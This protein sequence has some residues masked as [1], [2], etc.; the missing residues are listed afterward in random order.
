MYYKVIVMRTY[1]EVVYHFLCLLVTLRGWSK[2]F[3]NWVYNVIVWKEAFHYHS[4]M[5]FVYS[6]ICMYVCV[7]IIPTYVCMYVQVYFAP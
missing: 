6:F 3:L 7:F 1:I 2:L 4:N 5:L